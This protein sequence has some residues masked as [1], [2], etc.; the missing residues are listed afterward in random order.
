LAGKQLFIITGA[1]KGIGHALAMATLQLPE[2]DVRGI[3]RSQT[4]VHPNYTHISLD[5]SQPQLVN[6]FSFDFSVGYKT[7]TLVNNAGWIGPILPL[8]KQLATDIAQ[9]FQ[10]NITAPAVLSSTFIAQT[11]NTGAKRKILFV[12]SG[13]ANYPIHSWST[14]CSAKAA[15]NML[16]QTLS[17]ENQDMDILAVAPGIVDTDMQQEIR[18]ADVENFPDISRFKNYHAAGELV[19]PADVATQLLRVL[20]QSSIFEKK[21]FSLRDISQQ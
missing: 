3:S 1:S 16:A 5:L 7:I 2:T 17:L 20:E 21:V 19:H 12:S 9:A 8:H 4:I 13:A 11:K 15:T 14:Y 18:Q 6:D 10:V